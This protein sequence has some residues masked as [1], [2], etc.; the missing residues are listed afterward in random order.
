MF[1]LENF[2]IV[3][4]SF[5]I[6]KRTLNN[7]IYKKIVLSVVGPVC[8]ALGTMRE[9]KDRGF[10]VETPRTSEMRNPNDT[11]VSQPMTLKMCVPPTTTREEGGEKATM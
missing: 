11:R 7:E 9:D 10:C 5:R 2:N 4:H 8:K 3:P 1:R 6:S